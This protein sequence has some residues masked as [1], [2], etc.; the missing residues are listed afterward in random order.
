MK[1]NTAARFRLYPSQVQAERLTAWSHT[2]RAVWNTALAQRIWA[3]K[4]AQRATVRSMEQCSGLTEARKDHAWL[5]DLPAQCAQQVLRQLDT[6]YDNFWNPT[7]PAGF[8]QFKRKHHRQGVTFPGQAVQVRKVSRRMAHVKLPKLG[9]VRFRLS[10]P[11]G[12]AVRNA[13]VSRDGLGWHI[14]FGIHQPEPAQRPVNTGAAVGLDVGIACSVFVSDEDAERQRPNT[15]TPGERERLR[16]LEQRKARQIKYA[17]KHNGGKYSNR[18]RKTI[19]AIAAVKA[20]QARRRADW[21][22][23]LTTD[24][25]KNHGLIA[26]E[27]LK[28]RNML[29]SAKGTSEQPGRGVR[30]KAGLNRSVA[31]QGWFE[32]RRQLGYKTKRC[33]GELVA[34]PASGSSQTCSKCHTR[35]PESREGCGRLFMCVHCGHTDH[36][37]RN[38]AVIILARAFS[39]AGRKPTTVWEA[40]TAA[41]GRGSSQS[42]RSPHGQGTRTGS[43]LREPSSNVTAA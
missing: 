42:T 34:V 39:T 37:D 28:V 7:Q 4:S 13:T 29:R 21:N 40:G 14:S 33:G 11:L 23:K 1:A 3:Y 2:C 20:R 17:K 36:A 32:I 43:R 15:L 5:R 18:L 41:S 24:L 10:R 31:D 27:D 6:A 12:G 8:P 38:A 22:H 9:W 30:Q 25:A 16:G 35:D 19:A 26:V